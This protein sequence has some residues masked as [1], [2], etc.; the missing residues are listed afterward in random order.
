MRST[1][2]VPGHGE[3]HQGSFN[4]CSKQHAK[5]M[6]GASQQGFSGGALYAKPSQKHQDLTFIG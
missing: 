6:F 2:K 5:K 3:Q 4:L 1:Q